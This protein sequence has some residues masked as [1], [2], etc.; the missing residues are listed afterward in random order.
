MNLILLIVILFILWLVYSLYKAYDNIVNELK[1]IKNKCI[2]KTASKES[3]NSKL[4]ENPVDTTMKDMPTTM[5]K[6]L[7]LLINTMG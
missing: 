5:I 7:K 1:E 2:G 4:K 3:F 6:G